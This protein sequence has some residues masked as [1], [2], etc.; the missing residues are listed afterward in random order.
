MV[1]GVFFP[2]YLFCTFVCCLLL[3]MFHVYIY[4]EKHSCCGL[5]IC[6][7]IFSVRTEEVTFYNFAQF[8]QDWKENQTNQTKT[9]L[10]CHRKWLQGIS[11]FKGKIKARIGKQNMWEMSHKPFFW[12]CSP[13]HRWQRSGD[14]EC[15]SGA[16]LGLEGCLE[17]HGHH[18]STPALL[19]N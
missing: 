14:A 16:G 19:L 17:G 10:L 7:C 4:W 3:A 18:W 9:F 13:T 2:R 1:L 15:P 11:T 6:S 8:Q 5:F 12:V